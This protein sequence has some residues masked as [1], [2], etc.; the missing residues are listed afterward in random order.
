LGDLCGF[1]FF[2]QELG[3]DLHIVQGILQSLVT[4]QDEDIMS[5]G[6]E[7]IDLPRMRE[8]KIMA[9]KG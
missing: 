3:I 8:D 6:A 2:S 7:P 5:K 9:L 1:L 4:R